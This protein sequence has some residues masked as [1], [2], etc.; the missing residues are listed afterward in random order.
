VRGSRR[1]RSASLEVDFE[2]RSARLL[3]RLS[4][5]ISLRPFRTEPVARRGDSYPAGHGSMAKAGG[6]LKTG[7][8]GTSHSR[9]RLLPRRNRGSNRF[10]RSSTLIS[11][12][13][14][15]ETAVR[16]PPRTCI[17]LPPESPPRTFP[18]ARSSATAPPL[19]CTSTSRASSCGPS[20]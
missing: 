19:P 1:K 5:V 10:Y 8:G 12:P 16:A 2:R 6:G 20:K 17:S 7:R 18:V 3:A 13:P 9:D 4:R 15:V 14:E 11:D